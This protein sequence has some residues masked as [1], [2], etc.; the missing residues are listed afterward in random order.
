M[1]NETGIR[2]P[3]DKVPT[4]EFGSILSNERLADKV[5]IVGLGCSSFSTFFWTKEDWDLHP[6]GVCV[7]DLSPDHPRVQEW[8]QTIH[9]AIQL[10]ITLLDTAPWYGHGTSERVVGL[11]LEAGKDWINRKA[12][13]LNTKVGRYQADPTKQFDFSYDTTLASI[14]RSIQRM[15]SDYIDVLQLHDPEFA[16]TMEVL[17]EETIPAMR[18]AQEQGWCRALGMTGYPLE[19]QRQLLECS[20]HK[21]GTNIWDQALTYGHFNLHDTTLLMQPSPEVPSYVTYCQSIGTGLLAAA[22][23]SMGLLTHQTPP[24]WHPASPELQAACREAARICEGSGLD[25][26]S[27]ATLF[28]LSQPNIACTILGCK[29][30]QQVQQA[31]D[32][33]ERFRPVCTTNTADTTMDDVLAEVLTAT[34]L[35]ACKLLRNENTGPF[36]ALWKKGEFGWDGVAAATQFWE[37]LPDVTVKSWQA[38]A[39]Q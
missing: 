26:A 28:A 15:S 13:T 36:A 8:I 35:K 2:Q 30:K 3:M 7:E 27:L 11:S 24:E 1:T 5:S 34:E 6:C 19:V 12:L 25:I 21:F 23:L 33:A 20:L 39:T 17:L 32:L 18:Y 4:R 37:A 29:D 14:K 9:F 38:T 10:G 31:A 16:P 22:P